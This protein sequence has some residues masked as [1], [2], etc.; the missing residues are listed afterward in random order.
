MFL[1]FDTFR[2]GVDLCFTPMILAD[3]F[4]QSSKARSSEFATNTT[5]TPLIAQFAAKTVHDFIG[6]SELVY[7]Y[8][9][10]VDLNCGCPQRW[11][12]KDGYGCGLLTEPDIIHSLVRNF[13]NHL[14]DSYTISVKI[15]LL[16]DLKS[17]IELCRSLE[18][19]GVSFLT[20]HGRKA[21]HKTCDPVDISALKEIKQSLRIPIIANGNVKS[22]ENAEAV[23]AETGCNGIMSAQGMLNNPSMFTGAPATP[24]SCIQD[25]I[26]I[27]EYQKPI[28]FQCFHHHLV[29]M[30]E[31]V[32][33]KSQKK[34]FN[35]L[36]SYE[37]ILR[38]LY[39]T[40]EIKPQICDDIIFDNMDCAFNSVDYS[41]LKNIYCQTDDTKDV[42]P[43]DQ[44][45]DSSLSDGKYFNS[46][47]SQDNNDLDYTD[48]WSMFNEN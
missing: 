45:Y 27:C 6:A 7:P 18:K 48:G 36:T 3:S 8:V 11:A 33:T 43:C 41:V 34:I 39:Q 16:K 25:W 5:D 44:I 19:C 38:F 46:A 20:V 9:D 23:Y 26:N 32:L 10:G 40:Y 22:L 17:T 24:I 1:F 42:P 29:F 12:I 35:F 2:N 21:W 31:K 28:T 14:P 47:I 13:K 4:C 37:D 15:R 30:L